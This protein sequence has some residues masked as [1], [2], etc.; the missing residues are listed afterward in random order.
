LFEPYN[1]IYR[2]PLNLPVLSYFNHNTI[3]P[4]NEVNRFKRS[5]LLFFNIFQNCTGNVRYRTFAYFNSINLYNSSFNVS[6]GYTPGIHR[7]NCMF[8]ALRHALMFWNNN[9]IEGCI[10]IPGNVQ[11]YFSKVCF[12]G[13]AT[14]PIT[15]ITTVFPGRIVFGITKMVT[16]FCLLKSFNSLFVKLLKV[17]LKLLLRLNLF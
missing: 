8:N 6:C 4:D 15:A 14:R 1:K 7:N 17:R 2:F 10:A 16:A 3:H 12:Q 13:L 11:W 9:R 5:L